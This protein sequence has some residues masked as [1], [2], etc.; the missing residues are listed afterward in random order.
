MLQNNN[1]FRNTIIQFC[2]FILFPMEINHCKAHYFKLQRPLQPYN[3]LL[4]SHPLLPIEVFERAL[5]LVLSSGKILARSRTCP[6]LST[7]FLMLSSHFVLGSPLPPVS[8]THLIS[9]V[10][11]AL[12]LAFSISFHSTTR[13]HVLSYL[14]QI[15]DKDSFYL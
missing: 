5:H 15:E 10:V 12:S 9:G 2:L 4:L 14:R 8:Y 3:C 13:S 6:L 1:N 7:L 11:A